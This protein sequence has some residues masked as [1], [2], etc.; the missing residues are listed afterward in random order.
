VLAPML[1]SLSK[2]RY[3]FWTPAV[4]LCAYYHASFMLLNCRSLLLSIEKWHMALFETTY[5]DHENFSFVYHDL[6]YASFRIH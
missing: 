1:M 5:F 6:T 2:P 3:C 4:K